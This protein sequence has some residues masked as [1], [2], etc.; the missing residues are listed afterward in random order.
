M[1]YYIRTLHLSIVRLNLCNNHLTLKMVRTRHSN[2]N[3]GIVGTYQ[4]DSHSIVFSN[5]NRIGYPPYSN[6]H[7][8]YSCR[9][10]NFIPRSQ[11][12]I[13]DSS[14]KPITYFYT[15]CYFK[16]CTYGAE[17]R[18]MRYSSIKFPASETVTELSSFFIIRIKGVS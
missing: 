12:F 14:S 11:K 2:N 10:H 5:V 1:D 15:I 18:Q 16:R 7:I 9:K 13:I 17:L 8:I 6:R 4:C 3:I